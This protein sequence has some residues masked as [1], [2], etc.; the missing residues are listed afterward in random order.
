MLNAIHQLPVANP[1]QPF[2]I[3]PQVFLVIFAKNDNPDAVN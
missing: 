1:R 2:T 3:C